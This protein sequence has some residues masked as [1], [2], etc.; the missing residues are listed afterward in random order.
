MIESAHDW[1]WLL[2][3]LLVGAA[4]SDIRSLRIPNLIPVAIIL[5]LVLALLVNGA[6]LTDYA[7]AGKSGLIG[8][9]VGYA[10][11]YLR[12]MGGG[13]GKLFAAA[14]AWFT[15]AALLGVGFLVSLA[16]IVVA[17]AA[18]VARALK[19]AKASAPAADA[20]RSALK[21][22]IPYG[23]AIALGVTAAAVMPVAA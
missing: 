14:A 18:L 6:P 21:T 23:A 17:L 3:V 5:S 12:L 9:V 4:V 16:G 15:P 19:T 20:I 13:D 11:F 10:L 2:V 1:R 8:L 22:P 7:A